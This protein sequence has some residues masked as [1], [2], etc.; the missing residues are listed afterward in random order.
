LTWDDVS[1]IFDELLLVEASGW[2]GRGGTAISQSTAT[3]GFYEGLCKEFAT[4]GNLR[5]FL[6]LRE[7][8]IAAFHICLLHAGT[9]TSLKIG[10]RQEFAKESPGQVLRLWVLQW[11][12]AQTDVRVFDMLG[13]SSEN[14]LRWATGVED[15]YTIYVFESSLRGW[16]ARARWQFAPG[17]KAS[18]R[19]LLA[20]GN[21]RPSKSAVSPERTTV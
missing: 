4:L 19:R 12:F 15:L 6:Y 16:A 2:K 13:P 3:R 11:C 7:D 8:K 9:M 17:L 20:G 1:A 14:K 10:Y 21:A 18:F 5:V